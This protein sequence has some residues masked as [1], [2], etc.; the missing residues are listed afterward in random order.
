MV[1]IYYEG[2]GN[3]DEYDGGGGDVGS[4]DGDFI[5]SLN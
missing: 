4:G 2:D 1:I 5:K 3:E